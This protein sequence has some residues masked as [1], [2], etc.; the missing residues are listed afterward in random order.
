MT[1]A[2]FD[3][4]VTRLAESPTTFSERELLQPSHWS[5][6][7]DARLREDLRFRETRWGRW[8]LAEDLVANDAVYRWLHTEKRGSVALDA[9]LKRA[10]QV[11]GRRCVFCADD[12]RFVLRHDQVHLSASELS[13]QPVVEDKLGDL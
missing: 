1:R 4:L 5:L 6:G 12:P 8:M 7:E 13:R 11:F 10:S 2:S 3:A 9:G